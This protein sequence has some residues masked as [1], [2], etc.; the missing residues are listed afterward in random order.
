M[1]YFFE[2]YGNL[3]RGGPGD[4]KSTRRAFLAMKELPPNPAILDI[5]CGPGMQT[6]ELARLSKGKIIALDNHQPFLDKIEKDAKRAEFKNIETLNLSMFDMYF[7]PETFDI[8]WAEGAIYFLGFKT[9]LEKIKPFLKKGGY[10]AVTEPVWLKKDPPEGAKEF[11]KE[12][13]AIADTQK[14]LKIIESIGYKNIANFVLPTSSWMND[15]YIPMQGVINKLK[16]KYANNKTAME[17]INSA[18][19]EIDGFKKYSDYFGYEFY[20]VRK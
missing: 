4:N 20:V 1:K 8:I 10:A 6:M 7:E 13:P 15:Y 12:Y 16:I 17:V 2:V 5:G 9:G 14:H 18:Q 3:P 19:K 11:W